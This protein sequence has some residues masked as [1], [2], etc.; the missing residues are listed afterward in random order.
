MTHPRTPPFRRR[1]CGRLAGTLAVG[2]LLVATPAAAQ[3][4]PSTTPRAARAEVGD[5]ASRLPLD[6]RVVT[7]RLPNG[8]RYYIRQNAR[9]EKRAELRLAVNA[10]SVLEAND[11]R[12]LAHFVEHMAFNGTRRFERQELVNFIERIG[13]RF[14]AHL[15][16]FTSFDETVYMLRVPTDK[17]AVVDTAFQILEDWARGVAFDSAEVEKERGVVIEEWRA[18]LGAEERISRCCSGGRATRS[19]SRSATG[20]RS[21]HSDTPP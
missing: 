10:G 8:L 16:A 18:G 13:M 14:G 1:S 15:N 7:G 2:V 17:P 6:P 19:G 9:P 5:T 11:Q 21:R 3:R 4:A 12:G 20:G